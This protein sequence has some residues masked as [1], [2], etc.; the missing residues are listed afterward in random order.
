MGPAGPEPLTVRYPA[1]P[2]SVT[3]GRHR[4]EKYASEL[5]MADTGDVALA[6]TEAFGNAVGHAYRDTEPGS[7]ELT[8]EVLVPNTL[9]VTVSDDGDGM[10]LD[11]LSGGLG[12]GLSLIGSLSSRFEIQQ[13]RP[14]GT[15]VRMH[16]PLPTRSL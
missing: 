6:V 7:I 2:E 1:I 8:A 11:P 3:K 15:R 14:Q 4:V 16:F 9:R 13:R 12:L 10:T 5:G